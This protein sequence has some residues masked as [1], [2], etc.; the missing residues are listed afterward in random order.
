MDSCGQGIIKEACWLQTTAVTWAIFDTWKAAADASIHRQGKHFIRC[1]W[2]V[3]EVWR[4]V[5][6]RVENPYSSIKL[7][8][9]LNTNNG[10]YVLKRHFTISTKEFLLA[11][12]EEIFS[13]FYIAKIYESALLYCCN[14]KLRHTT[15]TVHAPLNSPSMRPQQLI[16][17]LQNCVKLLLLA[18]LWLG[19]LGHV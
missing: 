17:S 15:L 12:E 9:G 8:T 16:D 4:T 11:C 5:S 10:N 14:A 3:N 7:Q 13:L 19:H 18:D 1:E 2:A 6:S